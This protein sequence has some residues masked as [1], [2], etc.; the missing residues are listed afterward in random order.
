[1]RSR[2]RLATAIG[3]T[4][5]STGSAAIGNLPGERLAGP[6]HA[7]G[8][9]VG[10]DASLGGE[11]LDRYA[12]DLDAGEHLAYSGSS[13]STSSPTHRQPTACSSGIGSRGAITALR[14]RPRSSSDLGARV[15]RSYR[16]S[17]CGALGRTTPSRPPE[18][19]ARRGV[20]H[21]WHT[22]LVGCPPPSFRSPTWRSTNAKNSSRLA[23][24][25][26]RSVSWVWSIS[27]LD[28]GRARTLHRRP[29]DAR[30][31]LETP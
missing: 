19:G 23:A 27:A 1:M 18:C 2:G 11:V 29:L 9:V 28:A 30:D 13:D 10:E 20:S 16:R 8:R 21:S 7:H 17:R 25:S 15:G 5:R 22:R 6:M 12:V 3:A 24:S 14:P 26:C 31:R 4:E